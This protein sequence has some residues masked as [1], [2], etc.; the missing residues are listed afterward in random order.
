M[1]VV[2]WI[3]EFLYRGRPPSGP[4]SELDATYHIILKQSVESPFGPQEA[5]VQR[6]IGPLTPEQ[7]QAA[8]HPLASL[9]AG[10]NAAA[11]Q[12][13][14]IARQERDAAIAERDSAQDQAHQA[15][16]AATQLQ[17]QNET[18]SVELQKASEN[19]VQTNALLDQ[20][21]AELALFNGKSA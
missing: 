11:I 9:I 13:M 16:L 7:S 5:P 10:I 6:T 12:E 3:E 19:L 14:H 21:R 17:T 1:P 8:G 18:L 15:Q 20:A 4:G 2:T